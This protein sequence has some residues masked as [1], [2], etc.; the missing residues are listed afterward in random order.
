MSNDS[1]AAPDEFEDPLSD[2]EPTEYPSELHRVLAEDSV[3]KVESTPF[4]KLEAE[5]SIRE[6]RR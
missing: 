6:A 4:L 5:C 2:Y 3:S 1:P